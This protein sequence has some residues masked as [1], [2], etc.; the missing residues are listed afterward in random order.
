M[1]VKLNLMSLGGKVV[2]VVEAVVFGDVVEDGVVEAVVE[3]DVFEAE[4]GLE[5]HALRKAA[6]A[7]HASKG[8]HFGFQR[9]MQV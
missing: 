4:V 1:V 8:I 5:P 2:V 3:V 6:A 7:I 9:L